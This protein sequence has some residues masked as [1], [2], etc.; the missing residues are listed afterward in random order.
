MIIYTATVSKSLNPVSLVVA[1]YCF[2]EDIPAL[3]ISSTSKRLPAMAELEEEREG[4]C[5]C[6]CEREGGGGGGGG[7]GG[8]PTMSVAAVS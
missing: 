4:V 7:G 3:M 2:K 1:I 5:V 8:V 6:V